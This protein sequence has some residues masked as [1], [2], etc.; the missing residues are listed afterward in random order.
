MKKIVMATNNLGKIKE[1]KSMLNDEFIVMSQK[2]AGIDD[3]DVDENGKT[4]EENA[5][6]KA[7][8]IK[9]LVSKDTYIIAEDSGICIECLDGYPGVKTKR[10]AFEELNKQISDFE[11]NEFYIK[12]VGDNNNRKVVWQTVIA[13]IDRN[14]NLK[15]F[16]GEVYGL[17]AKEQIGKNGF[18]F[19]PI[20][21]ISEENK[22]LGQMTSIEKE[23]YS[24]RKKAVEKLVKYLDEKNI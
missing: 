21:Y 23:K 11:R 1:L 9:D 16:I 8:S 19:D 20:F 13:L 12:K 22:T 2:E 6:I 7:N 10:A 3:L 17:V 24:A 14:G 18:G 4:F 5:I 15:T